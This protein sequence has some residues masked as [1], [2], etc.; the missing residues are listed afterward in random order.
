MLLYSRFSLCTPISVEVV[1]SYFYMAFCIVHSFS[2][3]V[4]VFSI[5]V[6]ISAFK[7]KVRNVIFFT[8]FW[9][10]SE[11]FLRCSL[12]PCMRSQDIVRQLSQRFREWQ[13][14]SS[15]EKDT[16]SER[17]LSKKYPQKPKTKQKQLQHGETAGAGISSKVAFPRWW[18]A[19]ILF[20]ICV[21]GNGVSAFVVYDILG[22]SILG[23][24][25]VYNSTG[26]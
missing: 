3:W 24:K 6:A 19:K 17:S 15:V 11:D 8:S 18:W 16:G 4:C 2:W 14:S 12:Q 20:S 7:E 23:G 9:S 5:T 13:G 22:T 10:V 26:L 1:K 21:V 25:F